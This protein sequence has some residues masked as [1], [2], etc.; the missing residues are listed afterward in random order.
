MRADLSRLRWLEPTTA[1]DLAANGLTLL[2]WWTVQC[3]FCRDSLPD[4]AELPARFA[5]RGLTVVGVFH[6][7][8]QQVPTDDAVV[9]YAR[10]LGFAGPIAADDRWQVLEDLRTR[11][12][13]DAA[14]SISVLIDEDGTVRWV[15][16]GPRLHRSED[17]RFAAADRSF[18]ELEQLLA[19]W[20]R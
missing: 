7:K 17:P 19:E 20:Q 14:T 18:R 10:G 3:P 11:G 1:S 6:P 5:R 15:H 2:R 8:T 16:P 4:L 12:A 13:L 9:A